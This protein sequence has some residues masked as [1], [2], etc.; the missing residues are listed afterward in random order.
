MDRS[1]QVRVGLAALIAVFIF[2][3]CGNGN[4]GGNGVPSVEKFPLDNGSGLSS[5]IPKFTLNK[6]GVYAPLTYMTDSPLELVECT[7][8]SPKVR[9]GCSTEGSI[10]HISAVARTGADAT[11]IHFQVKNSVQTFDRVEVPIVIF[12]S[13]ASIQAAGYA[14]EAARYIVHNP[15]DAP[16]VNIEVRCSF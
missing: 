9:A 13:C 14:G 7:S 8:D 11:K 6:T 10:L 2:A 4:D 16:G 12:D 3:G 15:T 1:N 5:E